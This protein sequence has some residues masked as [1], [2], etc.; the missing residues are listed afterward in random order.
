MGEEK[1]VS[2]L[3]KKRLMELSDRSYRGNICVF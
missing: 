1:Q 3:T 2:E